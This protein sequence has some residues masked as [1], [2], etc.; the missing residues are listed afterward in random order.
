[1]PWSSL[2]PILLVC[3]FAPLA[4]HAAPPPKPVAALIDQHC[5]D[6]HDGD[7]KRAGSILTRSR[8]HPPTRATSTCGSRFVTV[9]KPVKCRQK[10]ERP[11]AKETASFLTALDRALVAAESTR[12]AAE[13]RATQRRLNRYEYENAVRDL[14]G[15]PWL[16]IR[17][18]LPEDGEAHRFNKIGE[19][20]DVSHVQMRPLPG[21]RRLRA[22]PS[23]G[24]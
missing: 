18:S 19:A 3:A 13:G 8:S 4:L 1:M 20:L 9:S 22:P 16:Q 15:A 2:R 14:L 6:C 17:D 21:R 23:D 11:A 7:E 24:S 10:R 5:A 12:L